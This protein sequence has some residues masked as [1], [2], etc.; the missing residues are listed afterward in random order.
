MIQD[1]LCEIKNPHNS[2]Y[3]SLTGRECPILLINEKV[4]KQLR[5]RILI[6]PRKQRGTLS[7]TTIG[8]RSRSVRESTFCCPRTATNWPLPGGKFKSSKLFVWIVSFLVSSLLNW[9]KRLNR[10]YPK[11]RDQHALKEGVDNRLTRFFNL[12]SDGESP[13]Q[14]AA[15]W[16]VCSAVRTKRT[17]GRWSAGKNI[18]LQQP[19]RGV[20]NTKCHRY[21]WEPKKL[22]WSIDHGIT[23]KNDYIM[24]GWLYTRVAVWIE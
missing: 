7:F 6:F 24:T 9:K 1:L 14:T 10:S 5:A 4:T 18:C 20:S 3:K 8:Q 21:F 22:N 2:L 23:P 16:R 17:V 19:V 15:L 11:E 12:S 13:N